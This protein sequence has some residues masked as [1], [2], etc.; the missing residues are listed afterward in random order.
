[1][2]G[3]SALLRLRVREIRSTLRGWVLPAAIIVF[4]VSGPLMALYASNIL[5]WALPAGQVNIFNLPDPT[6]FDAYGQWTST[7][8]EIM[9]FVVIV[10]AAG[11]INSEMRSGVAA[12]LL[13]KPASRTAYVLTHWMAQFGFVALVSMMGAAAT[14]VVTRIAFGQAPLGAVF[15]STGAWL[16]LVAVLVSASLLASSAIDAVAG[17]AGVGIG[18][19]FLLALLGAIPMLAR[20]TPA[21]LIS[22]TGALGAGTPPDGLALWLPLV[23]GA[24]LAAILL[25]LAITRFR[26]REL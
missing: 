19:Y 4:A 23:T 8:S 6:P 3:A 16:V 26:H 13:V 15:A 5:A 9:V 25:A 10:L 7:L 22:I 24:A 12:S 21:G 20:Y 11:A 14:W 1:M 2:N 17:A 18:V